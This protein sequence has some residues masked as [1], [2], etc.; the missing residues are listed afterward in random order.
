[1]MEQEPKMRGAP[2]DER[3]KSPIHKALE[4][5]TKRGETPV[6]KSQAARGDMHTAG[7]KPEEHTAHATPAQETPHE[8]AHDHDA[9]HHTSQQEEAHKVAIITGAS[10]GIGSAIALHLASS[11]YNVVLVSQDKEKLHEVQSELAKYRVKTILRECDVTKPEQVHNTVQ[12]TI[13]QLGRVDLLVNCAGYGVYGELETMPLKDINGQMLTN[14][15]GSVLFI[16]ECLPKLKESRGVIVNVASMA[17]LIGVRNMAAY[18]ASKHAVVGLSESLRF[19]LEGTGV[20]VCVVCPGKVKT[21]FFDGES[22]KSVDWAH[23]DS[24]ITPTEVATAV[25]RALHTR[26]FVHIVPNRHRIEL[27]FGRLLPDS[28]MRRVVKREM[29]EA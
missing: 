6:E 27:I 28:W 1:M 25:D 17:G 20:A 18:S 15:F 24:G 11:N 5:Q 16:K 23:D 3:P 19:E 2:A 8:D 9:G 10:G 14:Y 13:S 4:K 7:R 29:K 22:F 21:P 26:K 12:H